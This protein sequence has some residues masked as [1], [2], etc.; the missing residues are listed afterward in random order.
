MARRKR[1]EVNGDATTVV[2]SPNG[3]THETSGPEEKNQPAH[4]VR[5]R[6]VRA[7]VWANARPDGSVWYSTTFSRSYRD[8]DGNWHS[9]DSF[10]TADLLVLGEVARSAF[11]WI[12]ATT[13]GE[14]PF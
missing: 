4:V 7:A 1:D 11:H 3:E 10:G 13:Q 12:I 5:I 6:N 2:D 9:T 14:S 8:E